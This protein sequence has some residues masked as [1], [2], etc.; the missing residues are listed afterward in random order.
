MGA[1]SAPV[2]IT[3]YW[4]NFVPRLD[5]Q[6]RNLSHLGE[7]RRFTGGTKIAYQSECFIA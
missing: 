6:R 4:Q 1:K 3:G 7:K 2:E 5:S